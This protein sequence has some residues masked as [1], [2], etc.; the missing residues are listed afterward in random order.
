V[1][2]LKLPTRTVDV[3]AGCALLRQRGQPEANWREPLACFPCVFLPFSVRFLTKRMSFSQRSHTTLRT[4]MK[5]ETGS[6]HSCAHE[7]SHGRW[8]PG[9][10]SSSV[11]GDRDRV[12]AGLS[13]KSVSQRDKQEERSSLV[14]FL[15][16]ASPKVPM[17]RFG[18]RT[19]PCFCETNCSLG[20]FITGTRVPVEGV[21]G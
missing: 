18:Q 8:Q 17:S 5:D 19:R 14:A 15:F 10:R 16:R 4:I 12:V 13:P 9:I 1:I 7:E 6:S 3:R 21:A 20:A 2:R 11:D